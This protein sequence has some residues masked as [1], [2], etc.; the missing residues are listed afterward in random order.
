MLKTKI[1]SSIGSNLSSLIFQTITFSLINK[2][3][4]PYGRGIL[5]SINSY[6][7]TLEGISNFSFPSTVHY[8][9]KKE[10][11]EDILGGIIAFTFSTL[12][13]SSLIILS[14]VILE[15]GTSNIPN[16]LLLISIF[17]IF[18]YSLSSS[19]GN[20]LIS[21]GHLHNA[22]MLS[23]I[24]ATINLLLIFILTKVT[25]FSPFIA[26]LANITS[27]CV[28]TGLY[29]LPIWK[30]SNL[31]FQFKLPKFFSYLRISFSAHTNSLAQIITSRIDIIIINNFL[32]AK[33]AGIYFVAVSIASY[34]NH[35][36]LTLQKVFYSEVENVK[37]TLIL[38]KFTLL[39]TLL[40]SLVLIYFAPEI[41]ILLGG[42][43]FL[44]SVPY[45]QLLCLS[46]LI[47]SP[48]PLFSSIWIK[49]GAFNKLRKI[50]L[51]NGIAGISLNLI[52]I[53]SHGLRGAVYA[54]LTTAFIGFLSHLFLIKK[55]GILRLNEIFI[56][57]QRDFLLLKEFFT[58]FLKNRNK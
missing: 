16:N 21:T 42:E 10:R 3:L 18:F 20:L 25:S 44:S 58:N 5:S 2:A 56:P 41:I 50:S 7:L 30:N 17:F 11:Q 43:S 6:A 40:C 9:S 14:M 33:P 45:L 35:I 29:V 24:H 12:T 53:S 48:T 4:G 26:L 39:S 47:L 1:I 57:N 13:I 51:F 38:V 22:N 8:L 23:I 36:P 46:Q 55:H 52:L 34:L 32:G 15:V 27:Y 54:N 19:L 37:T 49:R 31:K 28:L